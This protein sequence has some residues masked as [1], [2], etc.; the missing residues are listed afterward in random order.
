[1]PACGDD[2][3]RLG[4]QLKTV[5][6]PT[7]I[8]RA[9]AVGGEA[10]VPILRTLSRP[11]EP[12][13]ST[14]GAAQVALARLGDKHSL[15]ELEKET[16]GKPTEVVQAIAKLSKVR[17][18]AS[19]TILMLYVIRN[20]RNSKRAVEL[21]DVG[22]DPILGALAGLIGMLTDPPYATPL[23]DQSRLDVWEKWWSSKTRQKITSI[24]EGLPDERSRCLARLAEDGFADAVRELYLHAGQSSVPA[25]E[26]LINLGNGGMSPPISMAGNIARA[27]LT[28]AGDQLQFE[29]IVRDLDGL[30]SY[31][32]AIET[33]RYVA[34]K[35][36][37][38]ALLHSLNLTNFPKNRYYAPDNTLRPVGEKLQKE[39]M[40]ALSQMV[41]DPPLAADAPVTDANIQTWQEWWQANQ[42]K[43]VLRT[44]PL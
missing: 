29:R 27:I 19:A 5:T 9:G 21:G 42:H 8:F 15:D 33:L 22:E 35:Q 31:P 43:D 34:N 38:E 18:E 13:V 44:V 12:S 6:D 26:T 37:F 28:K 7:Y 11:G 24:A 3:A 1:M 30:A 2:L 14:P 23:Y 40:A 39:V 17:S 25:L 20:R 10:L 16:R 32:G 41:V 4:N 36:S